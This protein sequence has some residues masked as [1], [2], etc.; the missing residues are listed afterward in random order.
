MSHNCG[1]NRVRLLHGMA[2]EKQP[3]SLKVPFVVESLTNKE[4]MYAAF[5]YRC[6]RVVKKSLIQIAL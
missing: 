1:E 6:R 3:L 5:Y 4:K 2:I